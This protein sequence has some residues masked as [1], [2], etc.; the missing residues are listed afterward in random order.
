MQRICV[1]CGSSNG[2]DPVYLDAAKQLGTELAKQNIGLVYGGASV[3]LMGAVA[4]AT[5]QGGGEVIGVIP[6]AIVDLEVAH[7]GLADLRVV[8][9]MHER[10]ALMAELSNGFVAM[11][12]GLGT[13]EELFEA[14]TWLQLGLHSDPCGLFNVNEYYNSLISFLNHTVSSGFAKQSHLTNL[15]VKDQA[16]SLLELMK[17]FS[18]SHESKLG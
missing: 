10:K 3:G 18:A 11:P 2:N 15:L 6:Q 7:Q 12:G 14:L 13:L 1:Y 5:L 8:A 17:G 4:D 16:P 9:G